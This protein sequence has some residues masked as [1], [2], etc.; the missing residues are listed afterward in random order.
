[1]SVR[2]QLESD[3]FIVNAFGLPIGDIQSFAGPKF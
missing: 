2:F 3:A 1:M